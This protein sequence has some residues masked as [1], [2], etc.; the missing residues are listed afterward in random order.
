MQQKATLFV[1]LLACTVSLLINLLP[2]LDGKDDLLDFGSFYAAGLKL[3]NGENPY[4]PDS[5]YIFEINFEKVGAGG[6]MANLNPPISLVFFQMLPMFDPHNAMVTWQV[7]SFVLYAACAYLLAGAYRQNISPAR[8]LWVF[9][10]AG[11]WH[12]IVLGQL[13]TLLLLCTALAWVWLKDG[14]FVLAGIAMGILV[15]I[16]PNFVIWPVF[17]LLSGY[18]A[19]AVTSIVTSAVVSIVPILIWGTEVYR[20]WFSASALRVETLIMP[21]NSSIVGLTGR[22]DNMSAGVI[23][24]FALALGLFVLAKYKTSSDMNRVEH[25]STLAVIASLLV[26][27]IS[28]PGY[29]IL[30]LPI[31]FSLHKWTMPVIISAAI[32]AIPFQIVLQMFQRSEFNFVFFGWLYGWGILVLLGE[33][34]RK[35]MT[36][37]SIQ[38]N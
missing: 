11:F 21:G 10:L 36:T 8:I 34:V 32:L 15:A 23:L 12:T 6:K 22:F 17:L 38:T 16:K 26:S 35:S 33:V 37:S 30:L 13:Y 5:E 19:S 28:W 27:P 1:V 9:V 2:F 3:E 18:V 4:D 24:S 7:V 14:K 31:F 29:S 20:Q 25:I